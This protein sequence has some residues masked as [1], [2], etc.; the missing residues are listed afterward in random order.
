LAARCFA[1]SL[2]RC[3]SR[4]RLSFR[5]RWIRRMHGWGGRGRPAASQVWRADLHGAAP[6][7][8]LA[9]NAHGLRSPSGTRTA[10]TRV[11]GIR[12]AKDHYQPCAPRSPNYGPS[13]QLLDP[14]QTSAQLTTTRH[15]PPDRRFQC[16]AQQNRWVLSAAPQRRPRAPFSWYCRRRRP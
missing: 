15:V 8:L 12:V 6:L 13:G 16:E 4:K 7:A 11:N 14:Q 9:N 1:R 2:C 5:S 3:I 10:S